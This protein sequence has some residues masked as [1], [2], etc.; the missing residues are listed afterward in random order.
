MTTNHFEN[1]SLTREYAVKLILLLGLVSLLADV[2][3]EGARSIVGPFFEVLGASATVVGVVTGLGEFIGYGLRSIFGYLSDK[4]GEYWTPTILGYL[5]VFFSIPT[6]A[7]VGYWEL[8]AIL[9]IVERMGKAVRT[10]ARD[11]IL[12]YA[13]SR[14]GRG[15][16]FGLHEAMDQMG[17][18]LGPL[19]VTAVLHFRGY[20]ESFAFLALPAGLALGVL[21]FCRKLYPSPQRLELRE[22]G[23]EG[24]GRVSPIF[25]VYSVFVIISVSGCAS[26]PLIAYHLKLSS[27]FSDIQIPI[28][29]A[30]AMGVDA[31]AAL[32][33]GRVYDRVRL[34][35]LVFI[36]SLILP[37]APL[38]FLR[39]DQH[40]VITAMLLWGAVMGVQETVMRAAVGEMSPL[41]RRGFTYG[42]F[43][44]LYG[45]SWLFGNT[46]MGILYGISP[47]YLVIFSVSLELL[48]FVPYFGLLKMDFEE[49]R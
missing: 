25:W 2:A 10:P 7:L 6:L 14:V 9:L 43:A 41:S 27:V 39:G 31:L 40:L 28:L 35:S 46:V 49:S 16:G 33:V 26:F 24:G 11:A 15:W 48:A 44:A 4:R 21:L 12:S 1:G 47:N 17:A 45:A 8:A 34:L 20:S 19:L 13:A 23:V 32:L 18:V 30:L 37:I 38:A 29:F 22:K 5:S 42:V 3:Y 36:P